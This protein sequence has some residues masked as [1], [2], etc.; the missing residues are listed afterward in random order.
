MHRFVR[1]GADHRVER[2]A[3]GAA[4]SVP[5]ARFRSKLFYEPRNTRNTRKK[6]E[7]GFPSLTVPHFRLYCVFRGLCVYRGSRKD[8]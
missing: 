4:A 5:G 1:L 3:T 7:E 8:V 2:T 6:E